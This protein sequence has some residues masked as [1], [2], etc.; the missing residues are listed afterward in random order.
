MSY[1]FELLAAVSTWQNAMICALVIWKHQSPS[2]PYH[3][4][5]LTLNSILFLPV[6]FVKAIRA[7][8]LSRLLRMNSREKSQK[9]IHHQSKG[10]SEVEVEV[11]VPW[12]QAPDN[13]NL[14]THRFLRSP[15]SVFKIHGTDTSVEDFCSCR[16]STFSLASCNFN[17]HKNWLIDPMNCVSLWANHCFWR[18][19]HHNVPLSILDFIHN[20]FNQRH[21]HLMLIQ[22]R[23]PLSSFF[24]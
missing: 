1:F 19:M 24:F 9:K 12:F 22:L 2:A 21:D 13:Q 5:L 4:R 20:L 15:K 18:L 8:H 6:S 23:W 7:I 3:V 11:E 17:S 16:P 10:P 14:P